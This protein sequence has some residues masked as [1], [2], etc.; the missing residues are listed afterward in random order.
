MRFG[1]W[2]RL[3]EMAA[4]RSFAHSLGKWQQPL[5]KPIAILTAFRADQS[6]ANN[7]ARNVALANDMQQL[8][9]G[10]YPVLGRGQED[11]LAL[12]GLVRVVQPSSE[13]SFVVQPQGEMSEEVFEATIRRLL[14][15]Y[16]QY[17]AMMKLPSTPQAFLLRTADGNREYKGSEVGAT[18]PKDDYYSQLKVG[19]R[20]DT[21]MLSPWE[22]R[23]ER[24]PI[25]RVLNWWGDRSEMNRPVDR[26]KIGRRFSVRRRDWA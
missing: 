16:E 3:E 17:G 22:I 19:P 25:K 5:D 14:Q 6:L 1:E 11:F 7:R 15:K 2:F 21:S 4:R 13:E 23:G 12:F 26:T 24:N 8:D 10:F 18:T 20:A 9:L